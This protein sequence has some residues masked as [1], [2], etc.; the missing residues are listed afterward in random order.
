MLAACE[1]PTT[2]SASNPSSL[3]VLPQSVAKGITQTFPWTFVEVQG[4]WAN[5]QVTG[6]SRSARIVGVHFNGSSSSYDGFIADRVTKT[7]I[8][9]YPSPVPEP[10][11]TQ[12]DNIYLSSINDVTS[13]GG[14]SW[15]VGFSPPIS[16]YACPS[17]GTVC[18]LLYQPNNSPHLTSFQ[19]PGSCG[20][21]YLYGTSDTRIQVGYYTKMPNCK[22]QAFEEYNNACGSSFPNCGVQYVD[23]NPTSPGASKAF[24][25]NTIGD[26]VG[27][28]TTST[29]AISS[30]RY[31]NFSYLPVTLSAAT[32]IQAFGIN[33]ANDVTGSYTGS[34]NATHGFVEK[35]DGSPW[36]PVNDGPGTVVNSINNNGDIVGWH[37]D[38]GSQRE[39]H[40]FVGVCTVPC[41]LGS[42]S[43]G[44]SSAGP[45][46]GRSLHQRGIRSAPR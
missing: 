34:D 45:M 36:Y 17:S 12:G 42:S 32:N 22:P 5:T 16:G 25:I 44:S 24:G 3:S 37:G 38:S 21:T 33:F 13:S 7:G 39:L 4:T 10:P 1:S 9:T 30:W 26:I 35:G 2:S 14:N 8:V 43:S 18:G 31:W 46:K 15:V 23:I 20:Q 27:T 41:P 29:G 19:V 28:S 6:I 11:N 40:G